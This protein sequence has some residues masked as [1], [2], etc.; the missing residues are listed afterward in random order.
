[1]RG[2]TDATH[3]SRPPPA[4]D[5]ERL[6][7]GIDLAQTLQA[8]RLVQQPGLLAAADGGAVLLPMAERLPPHT[9]AHMAQA[10]DR[11]AVLS[12]GGHEERP[13]RFAMVA[14]DE[15]EADETG[16]ARCRATA[17]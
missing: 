2:V 17:A 9:V 15:S 5:A 11:G 13:A 12:R 16:L 6:L 4:A 14:L 3:A 7:G 10:Q 1:M 8:G